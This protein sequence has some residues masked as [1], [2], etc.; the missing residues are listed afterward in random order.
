MIY[1]CIVQILQ[2]GGVGGGGGGGGAFFQ[3]GFFPEG[4]FPT[5]GPFSRRAFFHTP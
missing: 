3:E 2:L 5:W 4:F 1:N